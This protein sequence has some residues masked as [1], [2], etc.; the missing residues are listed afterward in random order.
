MMPRA[1][2]KGYSP[3]CLEGEF[4]EVASSSKSCYIGFER[5]GGELEQR[6]KSVMSPEEN[7]ALARRELEEIFA[8]KGNLDAAEEIYAPH[9]I[10]HQPPA[11]EDLSGPEAIKQFAAG[12]RQAFPDLEITIEEQIAEGDKVLTRFRTRGTHQGEL[13]GIPPTGKEVEITNMSMCRIEG[14]KMAEEWPA[15]DR[16]GMM[17][18]LGVIGQPSG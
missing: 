5:C 8:A 2:D 15:P 4:S 7:K 13:W 6:S 9:Y 17:Q 18:Q 11:E 1:L 14:G 3:S 16:L 10:S 12:M